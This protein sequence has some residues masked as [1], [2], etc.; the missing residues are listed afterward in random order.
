MPAFHDFLNP[1]TGIVA[2]LIL[3]KDDFCSSDL[4]GLTEK[5]GEDSVRPLIFCSGVCAEL[6]TG[7]GQAYPVSANQ[8][9]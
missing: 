5:P 2:H 6:K 4:A 8:P 9:D 7:S 1:P 3:N